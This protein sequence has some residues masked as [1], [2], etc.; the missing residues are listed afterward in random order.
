MSDNR[1]RVL[2]FA[3]LTDSAGALVWLEDND[4][5][6]DPCACARKVTRWE[7]ESHR[8]QRRQPWHLV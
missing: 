6:Y 1:N 3:E 8:M 7:H 2:T 5:D 4:G